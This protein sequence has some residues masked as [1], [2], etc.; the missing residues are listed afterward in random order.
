MTAALALGVGA[1]YVRGVKTAS[2]GA[3]SAALDTN[4]S[5]DPDE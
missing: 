2:L 3:G 5:P 1:A 4:D